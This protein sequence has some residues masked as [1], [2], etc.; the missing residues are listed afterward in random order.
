VHDRPAVTT[1]LFTDI[2]GSTRL[3]EKEPDKMRPAL[4]RHDTIVRTCVEGN[5]G[6]VVKM[7]GDGV[8]AVFADPLDAVRATLELQ[9]TIAELKAT[10]GVALQIRCGMHAG[11]DE[12]RDN[13]FFGSGVNRAARIMSVA[14]GGQVLLSQAVAALVSDRLPDGVSLRDLG[15]VRLRDLASPERVYQVVDP[16]LRQDFPALR[17]LE[18]CPN[19]LPQQVTSFVGRERELADISSQLGNTRLLTLFGAGGIGKTRLSLQV[20]AEVV[21]DYPDGIW[22]VDLAP[23]TDAHLVPQAAASVLSVREEVGRPVVEALVKFVSDRKLLLILDNCEHLLDACAEL[24]ARLLQSGPHLRI[25]AS[26]RQPL[27]VAGETTYHVPSLSVPEPQRTVTTQALA[28]YEAVRL[29]VDRAR[30]VQPLFQISETNLGTVADICRRLDGIPFAIELA[31]ARVRAL[32]VNEIAARLND[33]FRLL[34]GGDRTALPRQQTLQ[35]LMDWSYDLLTEYERALLRKLAVFAGGWTLEAAEAVGADETVGKT[36]ILDLLTNLIEKSL[37]IS[38]A[39]GSRYRLLE[40]VRQYAQERLNETS[41]RDP[42]CKR[43]LQFY[44]TLAEQARPELVGPNQ[45]AWLKRLDL[46][47]ENFLAA[48]AWCDIAEDGAL[49]GLKLTHGLKRYWLNRGLLGLGYR[50]SIEALA[51]AGADARNAARC[52]MLFDAGQLGSAMGRYREASGHLE[53][54]LSIARGLGNKVMVAAAL[55]PLGL[56]SLGLG[57]TLSARVHFEEAY[58]LA[59]ELKDGRQVAAALNALGQLDRL[60]GKLDSAESRYQDEL[61]IARDGAD[62]EITAA[63]LLNLAM[64]SIGRG[65]VQN[66]RAML[67]EVLEIAEESGFK[68]AGQSALEVCAGLS[69]ARGD[70]ERAAR[71]FG[72]A[73]MQITETGLQRDPADEAFLAPLIGKARD[74]LGASAFASAENAGHNLSYEAALVGARNWL[75]ETK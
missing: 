3:W 17:S 30:A 18:A 43:H 59:Q 66:V 51:R 58:A 6:T 48:N 72:A 5:R 29:F 13:D 9:R 49:I 12:R 4:A 56:A 74:A 68:P 36:D 26:S 35:A 70:W 39:D 2:E 41:E 21:D 47:R 14:H 45:G 22:F 32:S 1:Y 60:Q 42:T 69:A 37:V 61:R 52:Q 63:A 65:S 75:K 44:L 27:H 46:E 73:E 38:D 62:S 23:I 53:E 11:V 20:A 40:T 8:H 64:V 54:C 33:R 16:Q 25:L 15:S 67:L 34:T 10:E 50:V 28:Q 71:F 19:N 7:S 24:A 31:A 55:Q 57:D